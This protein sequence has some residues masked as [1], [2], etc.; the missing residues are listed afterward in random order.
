MWAKALAKY[1]LSPVRDSYPNLEPHF[2]IAGDH[3]IARELEL[4]G[5]FRSD[6]SLRVARLLRQNIHVLQYASNNQ[7]FNCD[8]IGCFR[9]WVVE[10]LI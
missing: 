6:S 10:H 7:E 2:H 8:T 5:Q 1:T 4:V 9:S 3:V